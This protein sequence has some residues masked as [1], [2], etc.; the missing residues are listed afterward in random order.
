M[1]PQRPV[2]VA[3]DDLDS[4][5]MLATVLKLNHYNVITAVNGSDCL[6]LARR[7]HPCLILL[8]LMM[9]VMGGE[10]FLSEQLR[11]P[12]IKD[13]PVIVVSARHQREL[14]AERLGVRSCVNKPIDFEKLMALVETHCDHAPA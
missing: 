5:V 9:P 4:R 1:P 6:N 8:D 7:V 2:L 14:I 11:D 3:E 13:I 10:E 12:A